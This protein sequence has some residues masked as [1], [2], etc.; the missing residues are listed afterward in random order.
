M[1][2]AKN[3]TKKTTAK[4]TAAKK[5]APKKTAK[6]QPV[7]KANTG[8]RHD[9]AFLMVE[10]PKLRAGGMKWEDIAKQLGCAPGLCRLMF[11][12][13][14]VPANRRIKGSPEAVAKAIVEARKNDEAWGFIAARAQMPEAKV[15]AIFRETTGK[16]D[17]ESFRVMGNPARPVGSKLGI[18]RAAAIAKKAA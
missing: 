14:T 11:M 16:S 3:T 5:T 13:A 17:K 18:K 4:K 10:V 1:T 2:K 8:R 7:A 6:K 12:W 15:R 9:R